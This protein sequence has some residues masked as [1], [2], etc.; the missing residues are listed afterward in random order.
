VEYPP[1]TEKFLQGH[2][3]DA[4]VVYKHYLS[5][6]VLLTCLELN[7]LA[8]HGAVARIEAHYTFLG[9]FLH[10]TN[11][12]AR[13]L[14]DNSNYHEGKPAI[15]MNSP[16]SS[17]ARLLAALYVCY[18]VAGLLDEI[19]H[20]HENAPETYIAKPGTEQ[21]RRL[22][23]DVPKRYA[24]FWFLFNDPPLYDKFIHCVNRATEEEWQAY[25]HYAN[26]PNDRVMF[27]Q[28]IYDQL[29]Q[30]LNGWSNTRVGTY[31]PPIR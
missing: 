5:Y 14:R 19:A 11:D 15:G 1:D 26:A 10:P 20:L 9:Q 27:N 18:L 31:T 6:D 3:K 4:A 29:K 28:H 13:D 25:G 21:L 17:T 12:A 2:Q 7:E 8:D 23:A 16:Y 24:Y 30:A 22:T